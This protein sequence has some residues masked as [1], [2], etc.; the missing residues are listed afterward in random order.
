M[1][2]LSPP[3]RRIAAILAAGAMLVAGCSTSG[4]GSE[5]GD[6]TTTTGGDEPTT[7]SGGDETTT[8][9]GGGPDDGPTTEDLEAILPAATD[10]GAGWTEDN[11]PD[12]DE[13][14]T[15]FEEQCPEVADVGLGD[16]DDSDKV[17]QKFMDTE[18]RQLEVSLSP[19]AEAL[20]QDQLEA[21][22]DAINQCGTITDTNDQGVTSSFDLEAQADRD[23]GEQGIRL[24]ADVTIKSDVLP[25]E[26]T[27]TLYSLSWREGTVGVQIT[28][29]DGIDDATFEAV[30]FETDVLTGLADDVDAQVEN[31]VG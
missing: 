14:N 23:Y 31:L 13:E 25:R 12:D 21:F 20:D 29:F 1:D 16:D 28:A 2:H 30:P 27:L 15:S 9:T 18:E 26:L 22:V 24:Q 17:T 10:I 8:S 3:S 7:T 6:K 11:T 4:G 19:T 5:G